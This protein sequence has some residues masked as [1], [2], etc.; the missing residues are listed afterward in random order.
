MLLLENRWLFC[1][2][3]IVYFIESLMFRSAI[4]GSSTVGNVGL[5]LVRYVCLEKDTLRF[6]GG[7]HKKVVSTAA[8]SNGAQHL[9]MVVLQLSGFEGANPNPVAILLMLI[10]WHS[11]I[12]IRPQNSAIFWKAK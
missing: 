8:G 7:P 3:R 5:V 2:L 12:G 9:T 4:S 11:G 1:M 6:V 10:S